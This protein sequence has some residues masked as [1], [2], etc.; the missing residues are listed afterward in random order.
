MKNSFYVPLKTSS[1]LQD[2]SRSKD[3]KE[4]EILRNTVLSKNPL[5]DT[6]PKF[7][8]PFKNEEI[9]NNKIQNSFLLYKSNSKMIDNGDGITVELEE[10]KSVC[11]EDMETKL[12]FF[13]KK[14]L[15]YASK[16]ELLKLKAQKENGEHNIYSLFRQFC[17]PENGKLMITSMQFLVEVLQFPLEEYDICLLYTSPSPRDGLLSRMP[18]SA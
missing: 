11:L 16:I 7:Q 2:F 8:P 5:E 9:Q 6:I 4:T 10:D 12:C 14:T 15:V 18:S 3:N 17:D 13:F 1:T